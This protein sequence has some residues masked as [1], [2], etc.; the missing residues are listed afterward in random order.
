MPLQRWL[1]C[2]V[3]LLA[4]AG[5]AA[6]APG[7]KAS[8]KVQ[9]E[10]A[11]ETVAVEKETDG[12]YRFL[13]RRPGGAVEPLSPEEFAARVHGE[14][15]GRGWWHRVLN[16]TSVWG[17]AWVALGLLGQLLFSGRMLVQWIASERYGRSVVP[18]SFWWM[19]VGGAS[20]LIAYFAW[21][22]DVVGILGQATGWLIYLRNIW[23][24]RRQD[25]EAGA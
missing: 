17:V 1:S 16:I 2:C 11:D 8:V 20:L 24:I 15:A 23:L 14:Q 5:S 4:L 25:Q 9:L 10:G 21:R 12:S 13:L 3:L 22:K 18:L 6:A 19:S 7:G